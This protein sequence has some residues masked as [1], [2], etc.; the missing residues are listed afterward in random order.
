MSLLSLPTTLL[1]HIASYVSQK[2]KDI[3][4]ICSCHSSLWRQ[5]VHKNTND[6]DYD[7]DKNDGDNI[8]RSLCRLSFPLSEERIAHWPKTSLTT[9]SATDSIEA[10]MNDSATT[11]NREKTCLSWMSLYSILEQWVPRE[12][13]YTILNSYP[14]GIL[15][16]LRFRHGDLVGEIIWHEEEKDNDDDDDDLEE[17]E[18]VNAGFTKATLHE[19]IRMRFK[20]DGSICSTSKILN[21]IPVLIQPGE[22][23]IGP[24]LSFLSIFSL[25]SPCPSDRALCIKA[26]RRN[27]NDM[28]E[29]EE[30]DI[31]FSS[32]GP[33]NPLT[34]CS[35]SDMIHELCNLHSNCITI[36]PVDLPSS[37]PCHLLL[38]K[39]ENNA[40][41][42]SSLVCDIPLIK[43]GLYSGC[44]DL[45]LYGKFSTEI[46]RVEYRRYDL[47]KTTTDHT[48][49]GRS[50]A[51][52]EKAETD[53]IWNAIHR[54]I[55]LCEKQRDDNELFQYLRTAIESNSNA[56]EIVFV[57]GRKVTGDIHV[58][59]GELTW[60]AVVYPTIGV[61]R[62]GNHN[63]NTSLNRI[64]DK[65]NSKQYDVARK[66][67][68]FGTLAYPGFQS[69]CWSAGYL[70]QLAG[71]PNSPDAFGF[72]WDIDVEEEATILRWLE[73]QNEFH[74]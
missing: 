18:N 70:V 27:D 28:E 33:W 48:G 4:Q 71:H 14:W 5:H 42:S 66:W 57:L 25:V 65:S 49:S 10:M 29:E 9:S 55:F 58:C 12:G 23:S 36:D 60:G 39:S 53:A 69:P 24:V 59:A 41:S 37:L 32:E 44:Y 61:H 30:E 21:G 52:K 8:W 34:K 67:W 68:G 7:G 2:Q 22:K 56:N 26:L 43:P 20:N 17:G 47:T 11:K 1:A 6:D 62:E 35:V 74:Q 15:L 54:D 40:S 46:M 13:F 38:P 50:G 73:I 16:L 31:R 3:I 45:Q 51:E 64:V 19:I 63:N 72:S